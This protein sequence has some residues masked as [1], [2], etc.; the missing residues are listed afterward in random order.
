M[1]DTRGGAALSIKL[2]VNKPIKFW[3]SGRKWKRLMY[4]ILF[5]WRNVSLE[6]NVVSFSGRKQEQFDEEEARKIQK[7]S[8]KSDSVL[9]IFFLNSASE[10]KKMGN[11]TWF[12]DDTRCFKSHERRGR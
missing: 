5:V 2:L 3:H 4:S 8:R 10:E 1:G 6:W 12:W 9:M 7:K 11:R